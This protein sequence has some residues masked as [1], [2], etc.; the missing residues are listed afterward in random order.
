MLAKPFVASSVLGGIMSHAVNL[1]GDP[2]FNAIEIKDVW[3]ERMPAAE[4]EAAQP[5]FSQSAPQQ[6]LRERRFGPKSSRLLDAG[7][8]L[9]R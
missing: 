6:S 1:D 4:A 5:A 2:Q 3:A 8:R 7:L 9:F